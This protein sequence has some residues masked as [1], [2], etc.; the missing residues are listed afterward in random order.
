LHRKG[1][2]DKNLT[3]GWFTYKNSNQV[4][5]KYEVKNANHFNA[6]LTAKSLV[7]KFHPAA[8]K[9][10]YGFPYFLINFYCLQ[11]KIHIPANFHTNPTRQGKQDGI[12]TCSDICK[13]LYPPLNKV[14][15]KLFENM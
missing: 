14:Q 3:P 5:T 9:T 1:T 2:R 15:I 12:Q 11:I 7:T 13:I 10:G 8:R 6:M 4:P